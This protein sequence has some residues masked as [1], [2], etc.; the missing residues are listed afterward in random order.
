MRMRNRELEEQVSKYFKG[1]ITSQD[2]LS[3]IQNLN[4]KDSHQ[5]FLA[6]TVKRL[7]LIAEKRKQSNLYDHDF[8]IA[9]RDYLLVFNNPRLDGDIITGFDI[10][11]YD[12]IVQEGQCRCYLDQIPNGITPKFI[13]DTYAL[14]SKK[15]EPSHKASLITDNKIYDLT[16]YKYFKSIRQ[17]IAVYGALKTPNGYTTLISLP[18][19][20]GKSLITQSIAYQGRG[21][22]IVIVP[23]V[24]L[25]I[26]QEK[27]AKKVIKSENAEEEIF[28]YASGFSKDKQNLII[29]SIKN[30]TAKLLFISP[31]ALQNNE[32]FKN[33]VKTANDLKYLK[34]IVI[35]EAHIV[36]DWGRNFRPEFQSLES[37]RNALMFENEEI[38]TFLLSA[39]FVERDTKI[40]KNL[41]SNRDKWIEIRCDALRQEPRFN[42]IKKNTEGQKKDCI[43]ELVKKL[44]HPMII[45]TDQ[46]AHAEQYKKL[47]EAHQINNIKT[48]T[49]NTKNDE[50]KRLINEWKNDEFEIMIATSAFGVG[51]D[52]SD[53]R[54]VIHTYVPQ[55]PN[56][57]YQELGRGGRDGL[58][59]L[60]V[61]CIIPSRDLADSKNKMLRSILSEEKIFQRWDSM[62]NSPKSKRIGN[63]VYI[64]TSIVPNYVE[65]DHDDDF[66]NE[67]HVRWNVYVLFL[68]RR[69][70]LISIN[71]V[72][73]DGKKYIF[74][75]E[76][77]DDVLYGRN[78][79]EIIDKIHHAYNE[80]AQYY[81]D[82][83]AEIQD[84]IE[85]AGKECWSEMF[86]STYDFVDEYC[87]GCDEHKEIIDG[88]SNEILKKPVTKPCMLFG[89]N[90][91]KW[92][93]ENREA[94][95]ITSEMNYAQIIKKF[96]DHIFVTVVIPNDYCNQE[97]ESMIKDQ[98]R[99]NIFILQF[100]TFYK[101]I[102][103]GSY[104]FVSGLV[105]VVYNSQKEDQMY[106]FSFVKNNLFNMENIRIIHLTNE[107]MNVKNAKKMSDYVDGALIDENSLGDDIYV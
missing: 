25:A 37:W 91:L 12:I 43:V 67:G 74:T 21:L 75:I 81:N 94:I 105:I 71:N 61:M 5:H 39:T 96:A 72:I 4:F 40:L 49:G 58:P 76:I 3:Y 69:C 89:A 56:A 98:T 42:V 84:H 33:I 80:E 8:L 20:G 90:R 2:I 29:S 52:K 14:T 88:T 38:R 63:K 83:F 101:L 92:L 13:K 86:Y 34:N 9:L 11:D 15:S 24:S 79:V 47:L 46:P 107:D 102:K 48:F 26:D 27:S 95:I 10:E 60:S 16:G 64:D 77:N 7:I 59:C 73:K 51:V 19:G 54:T 100:D 55:N 78:Q 45:Y 103:N 50:R 99:K 36:V 82:S 93:S 17:K 53:I 87:A 22:T 62:F 106:N 85:N 31:E 66:S 35:D 68:L 28:Y 65:S 44:P 18:T 32:I 41:F 23:T 30:H 70:N 6:S 57:Y 97:L 1:E 104:F